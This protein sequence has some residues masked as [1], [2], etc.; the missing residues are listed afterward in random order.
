[1]NELD[2]FLCNP[3]YE[4]LEEE[5]EAWL[6]LQ[7]QTEVRYL[8]QNENY[9]IMNMYDEWGCSS[10]GRAIALHAIGSAF[11]SRHLHQSRANPAP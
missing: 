6:Q 5:F 11:D 3:S 10:L 8:T 1:M 4:E 9:G 2:D 7:N